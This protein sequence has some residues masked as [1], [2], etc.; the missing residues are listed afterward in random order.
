MSRHWLSIPPLPLGFGGI[1]GLS[2]VFTRIFLGIHVSGQ[3]TSHFDRMVN[4]RS[5]EPLWQLL[6]K[7]KFGMRTD[8]TLALKRVAKNTQEPG[9]ISHDF[10]ASL[11]PP[12]VVD[13]GTLHKHSNRALRHLLEGQRFIWSQNGINVGHKGK[14]SWRVWHK[15]CQEVK[16]NCGEASQEFF[17]THFPVE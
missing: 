2:L 5:P 17:A 3:S 7:S 12:G 11:P 6:W 8:G 16:D 13:V 14:V 15:M 10:L 9:F 1:E 4:R